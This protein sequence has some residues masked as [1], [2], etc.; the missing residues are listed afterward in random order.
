MI[1]VRRHLWVHAAQLLLKQGH[2]EEGGQAYVQ[3]TL[4]DL[5]GG[6]STA[7]GQPVPVLHCLHNTE[8]LPGFLKEPAVLQF[9]PT[10]SCPH[11]E[12]NLPLSSLHP[13][14]RYLY[15][16]IRLP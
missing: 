14:F 2:A 3:V 12:N 15:T 9:V 11:T 10:A 6:G 5:Q 1:E 7:S 13:N 16:L 8:V 4:E